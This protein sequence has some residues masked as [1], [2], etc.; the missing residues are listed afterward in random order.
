MIRNRQEKGITLIA[1]VITIIVMLILVAVTISMSIN[2]GLFE[3]AGAAVDETQNA[4]EAEQK[5]ADGKIKVDGVWYASIDD[6]IA[7]I[8]LEEGISL[9]VT[10]LALTIDEEYNA[11]TSTPVTGQITATLTEIEGTV[12]WTSDN[13]AVAKVSNTGLVTAIAAGTAKITASVTFEGETYTAECNVTVKVPAD[14]KVGDYVNYEPTEGTYKVADASTGYTTTD[15]YQS[16]STEDLDWRILSIDEITGEVELV[17]ATQTS[18]K[19]TIKGADGY[20][21]AV[22]ILNDMCE[23][24]YSNENG[25]TAR[26]IKVEDINAKTTY[27]PKTDTNYS[28]VYDTEFRYSTKNYSTSYRKYPNLYEKED[29]FYVGGEKQAGGIAGSIGL[30]DGVTDEESG[31]TTYSTVTGYT[32]DWDTATSAMK[33]DVS[34]TYTYYYYNAE[35]YLH[36]TLG[37]NTAP[38]GLLK[39]GTTYW[40]ASRCVSANSSIAD[41]NVRCMGS[42]GY[43]CGRNLFYSAGST[44]TP[45]C[46]VRPVVP[47]GPNVTLTKDTINTDTTKTVWNVEF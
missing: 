1:L 41:F 46:A 9:D 37:I 10:T 15:G 32:D 7:G 25:A 27:D 34:V 13:E 40:L 24:L 42:D 26:S 17:A 38:A 12:T 2:G 29:G 6:Y 20:N 22:D 18:T 4:I 44:N 33:K 39:T 19:L 14:L 28:S 31:I 23:E 8:P 36:T 35:N 3:Y 16:F 11:E 5:L 43:V 45:G 30:G 47:L 21:H